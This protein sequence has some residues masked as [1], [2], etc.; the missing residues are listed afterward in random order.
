MT[1][2]D[3]CHRLTKSSTY[4]PS[5]SRVTQSKP[6]SPMLF[7]FISLLTAIVQSH[8]CIHDTL[9][10]PRGRE[11]TSHI[12]YGTPPFKTKLTSPPFSTSEAVRALATTENVAGPRQPIRIRAIYKFTETNALNTKIQDTFMPAALCLWSNALRVQPIKGP[13]K[14]DRSCASSWQ[15]EGKPCARFKEGANTC[16]AEVTLEE[17]WMNALTACTT[18]PNVDCTTKKAGSGIAN[19][20][21]VIIVKAFETEA[22]KNSPSTMGYAFPCRFDQYDRP[23]LGFINFCPAAISGTSDASATSTAAHELAHAL[24]FSGSSFAF[25]REDDG[26]TPRTPRGADG[27]PVIAA[28][29]CANGQTSTTYRPPASTTLQRTTARGNPNVFSIVTPRVKA[30]TIKHFDCASAIG[31]EL[32]NQPKGAGC[33]G[34]HWVCFVV[35]YCSF[36]CD[37]GGIFLLMCFSFF[38]LDSRNNVC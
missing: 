25:M 1:A 16:G 15:V 27:R 14:F 19:A 34:S 31:A 26:V 37:F 17:E 33:W 38:F 23:I 21:Y 35:I 9:D 22:C 12:E 2:A 7:L 8:H 30:A 29:T 28:L 4:K 20:D 13:I 32:E 5:T 18:Q 10:I 3:C 24:G 36:V 6:T 11:T